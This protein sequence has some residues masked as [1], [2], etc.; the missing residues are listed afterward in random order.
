MV[1]SEIF[2]ALC[3]DPGCSSSWHGLFRQLQQDAQGRASLLGRVECELPTQGRAGF[4]RATLLLLLGPKAEHLLAMRAGLDAQAPEFLE[5]CAVFLFLLSSFVLGEGRSH[6]AVQCALDALDLPGLLHREARELP[7][8]RHAPCSESRPVQRVALVTPALGRL[9]HPPTRLVF[10]HVA[11]LRRLGIAV[12][13]FSAEETSSASLAAHCAVPIANPFR[14]HLASEWTG[15]FGSDVQVWAARRDEPAMQRWKGLHERVERFAPDVVFFIGGPSAVPALFFPRRPL[16]ALGTIGLAPWTQADVW[17]CSRP[18]GDE[19]AYAF[20]GTLTGADLDV[21]ARSR[22][23]LGVPGRGLLL[24]SVGLRLHAEIEGAWADSMRRLLARRPQLHW[25]LVGSRRPPAL[26]GAADRITVLGYQDDLVAVLRACD[27]FV[28]P[29]RVGGGLSV[30]TAMACGLPVVSFS[31]C[32]GGDKVGARAAADDGEYFAQLEE[33]VDGADARQASGGRMQ[34]RYA[35]AL[36]V[37]R[38]G[39]ALHAA[40]DLARLRFSRRTDLA[41]AS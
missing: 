13:V 18:K 1:N 38:A 19:L 37:A 10:A 33:L 4:L 8:P 9:I 28:N 22:A 25:L 35:E 6:S 24:V 40:L 7:T 12:G 26:D 20:R 34:A 39:P 2:D 16:L 36:D 14:A 31:D 23:S 5:Q 17:L 32:D 29:P 3:G 30:A 41:A 11:L 15:A 27:V 21:P